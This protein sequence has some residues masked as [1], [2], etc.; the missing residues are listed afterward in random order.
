MRDRSLGSLCVMATAI[1]VVALAPVP[2]AGQTPTAA[3]DTWTPP[4]TPDGQPDLQGIWDYR[5]MTPLQRPSELA[6]REF[7]T[8][9]EAAEYEKKTLQR[10]NDY[11]RSPSVHAKFWLDYGAELT[12]DNRTSLIVEPPDGRIPP[13]TPEAQKRAAARGQASRR[14]ARGF[15]DRSVTE[16]CLVGFNAGP[17]M[18]PGAYNNNV[19]VFQI[20]GYVVML[21]EMVHQT[22][23]IPLDGRPHLPEHIRQ[24]MGDSRGHW[25]GETLVVDTTNFTDK[26]NF[27]GS[28]AHMRLVE[29]FTRVDADTLLYEYTIDDPE[30]FTRPWTAVVPMTKTEGPMFEFACHEGNYGLSN[31]LAAARAQEK[32]EA[33]EEAAKKSR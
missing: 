28:G 17:P 31:I 1:A 26:T 33:A 6:G 12:E 32:A 10:R 5:T 3:A 15:E 7:L 14:P 8:D 4:R 19:H 25:E 2:A 11:D 21:N 22:R 27:S 23:V 24:W 18:N 16:R 20:P 9:E 13:L 30:S 29:R